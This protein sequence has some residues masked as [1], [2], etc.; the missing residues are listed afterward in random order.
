MHGADITTAEG[1]VIVSGH[2]YT[3]VSV[4]SNGNVTLRN[5]WGE[6]STSGKAYIT[7]T[8]DEFTKDFSDMSIGSV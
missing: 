3:V 7:V 2:E 1:D 4:D 5:P 6:K 8:S